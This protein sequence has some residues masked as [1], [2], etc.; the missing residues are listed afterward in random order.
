MRTLAFSP[1][2]RKLRSKRVND[3]VNRINITQP[4]KRDNKVRSIFLM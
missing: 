1:R 4:V 2:H 3:V